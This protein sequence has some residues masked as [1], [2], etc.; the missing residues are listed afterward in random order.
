MI[1]K[2]ALFI[3]ILFGGSASAQSVRI[4]F[5]PLQGDSAGVLA[6]YENVP[7]EVD[8]W[9]RF[10]EGIRLVGL[11]LPLST[12]DDCI[13][14]R[15]YGEILPPLNGW[16]AVFVEPEDDPVHD[17]YTNQ[18]ILAVCG[19]PYDC[20]DTAGTPEEWIK[21]AVFQMTA[22]QA[23]EFDTTYCDALI[24]GYSPSEGGI[25]VADFYQGELDSTQIDVDF[26]C[27]R[28]EESCG[29]Y[30]MGDYNGNGSVNI[31]DVISAFSYITTC[32]PEAAL[33]CQC[34]PG[35][36]EPFAVAFDLNGS[37]TFNIADIFAF[38][39][40]YP[41]HPDRLIPCRFCPPEPGP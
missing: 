37:C 31:A 13:I 32:S 40:H 33:M 35:Q 7:I 15:D 12:R 14:S 27:I 23:P 5:G 3:L 24:E 9:I 2:S 39:K 19:F 25:I 11:H 38:L 16:N 17:G 28:F 18:S 41:D 21:I 34:P 6:T 22:G 30:V 8:L 29:S 36:G 10:E 4:V 20:I 26:A 1:K